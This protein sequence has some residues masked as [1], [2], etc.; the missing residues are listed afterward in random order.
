MP[1]AAVKPAL[2]AYIFIV[3]VKTLVVDLLIIMSIF[4]FYLFFIL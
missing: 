1:A 4:E 3:A 2:I